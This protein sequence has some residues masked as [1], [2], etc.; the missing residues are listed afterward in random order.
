MKIMTMMISV[1]SFSLVFF[2]NYT[3]SLGFRFKMVISVLN[4]EKQV[5]GP[6]HL[7]I[8]LP[9]VDITCYCTTFIIKLR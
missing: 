5:E 4:L 9:L 1:F 8:C 2:G 6:E 3:E 7:V